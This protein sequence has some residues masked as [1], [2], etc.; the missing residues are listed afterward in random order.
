MRV[1]RFKDYLRDLLSGS[2]HPDIVRVELE[3]V[4]GEGNELTELRFELSDGVAVQLAIVRTSP[5]A[6][7][8]FSKPET[9]AL[10]T[11]ATQSA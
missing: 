4:P 6:G 9:P 11:S 3:Q 10:K 2:G 5:P 7:D 8:D 1:D